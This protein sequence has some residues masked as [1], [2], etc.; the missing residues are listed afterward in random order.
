MKMNRVLVHSIFAILIFTLAC[1]V[2]YAKDIKKVV[3]LTA[4]KVV[5]Q[6]CYSNNGCIPDYCV[7]M[8]WHRRSEVMDVTVLNIQT[9]TKSWSCSSSQKRPR[10]S[11]PKL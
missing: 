4:Y 11:L 1:A 5:G 9:R 3:F 7:G 2:S 8:Q 6:A 10:T